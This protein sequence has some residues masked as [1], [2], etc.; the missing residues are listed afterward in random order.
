VQQSI[1]ELQ[2]ASQHQSQ[3]QHQQQQQGHQ[4]AIPEGLSAKAQQRLARRL[5]SMAARGHKPPAT[6]FRSAAPGSCCPT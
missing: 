4:L 5:A 2:A 3:Q 6:E 1:K